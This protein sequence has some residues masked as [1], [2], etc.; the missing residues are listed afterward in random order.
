MQAQ[1]LKGYVIEASTFGFWL[2][3]FGGLK[4]FGDFENRRFCVSGKTF[5]KAKNFRHFLKMTRPKVFEPHCNI[6]TFFD[7]EKKMIFFRRKLVAK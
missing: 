1:F 2:K 4:T 5:V 6:G 7:S 3:T